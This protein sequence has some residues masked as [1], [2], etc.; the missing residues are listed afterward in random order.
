MRAAAGQ[1]RHLPRGAHPALQE[2]LGLRRYGAQM[3]RLLAIDRQAR[4]VPRAPAARSQGMD[5]AESR[6]YTPGDDVRRIDWRVTART[7]RAHTKL[8]QHERGN[9]LYCIVDQR[10]AMHFGTCAAFKSVVAAQVAALAGWAAAAGGD[11]FG[12]LIAG[13][14]V[15]SIRSGAAEGSTPSLCSALCAGASP[16]VET[17]RPDSGDAALDRLAAR[18]VGEAAIGTRF[19]VA[20][21]F[22]DPGASV[23]NA[24]RLLRARGDV[25]LVWVFD[26]MEVRLPPPAQYPL[27][28]GYDSLVLDTAQAGVRAAHARE[29]AARRTRLAGFAARSGTRCLAVQTGEEL[30]AALARPFEAHAESFVSTPSHAT[31]RSLGLPG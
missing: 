4:D 17:S 23:A 28:D 7:G 9:D 12:A 1:P 27:T 15:T 26:P 25:V 18:A 14:G 16:E 19:V 31:V 10:A 13:A 30:F 11:R 21:D 29:V 6:P 5:Y 8:F 22:A 24:L 20:S 2:L 3:R